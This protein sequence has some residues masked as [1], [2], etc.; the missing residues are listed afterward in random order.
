MGARE[1]M[2]AYG[3]LIGPEWFVRIEDGAVVVTVAELAGAKL[4][5]NHSLDC[6]A[7]VAHLRTLTD[8]PVSQVV[9]EMTWPSRSNR[10]RP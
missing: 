1:K 4:Y 2:S 10:R 7:V 9:V 5:K 8:R 3:I 6:A